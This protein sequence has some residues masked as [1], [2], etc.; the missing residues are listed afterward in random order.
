MALAVVVAP[1]AAC[2]RLLATEEPEPPGVT[3]TEG[4]PEAL[5]TPAPP[6]PEPTLPPSPPEI[7]IDP[8]EIG[9]GESALVL[10]RQAGASAGGVNLLGQRV[11][12]IAE[13]DLL[14]AVVGAGLLTPTGTAEALVTT[15]GAGGELL[16]EVPIPLTVVP[17]ERPV[18]YLTASPS[19][20]AVLTVEAAETE[21]ALRSYEQFNLF[22]SR[23]RWDGELLMPCEGWITTEFGQGRSLNGGP[24]TGQHSG[25]DIANASGTPIYSAASGRIAWAGWMPIRGNSVLVDHGAGVVTGY[26]H[27]LRV[28]VQAGRDVSAGDQIGRMGSTGFSTGPHLHWEMTVYGVN[29]DPMTWTER[30]FLPSV[31]EGQ[32]SA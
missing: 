3:I 24:V 31:E 12:L 10:V 21:A 11:P 26:H 28:D 23:P 30:V 18:D 5:V 1:L 17:V 20:T 6:P 4:T 9:Q 22:Q 7:T 16:H 14:W 2:G 29:V 19:V 25:T 13:G 15:R 27:L 32:A 8:S